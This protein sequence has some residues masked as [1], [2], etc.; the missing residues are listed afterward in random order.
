M[1]VVE[2]CGTHVGVSAPV[3]FE[4][5]GGGHGYD[6]GD[7]NNERRADEHGHGGR[8][9]D[10]RN[11]GEQGDRRKNRIEELRQEQFEEALNLL[12]AFAGGLDHIR[13]LDARPVGRA[14]GHH[15]AVQ[16]GTQSEL[17]P[18]GGFGAEACGVCGGQVAN[19]HAD[20]RQGHVNHEVAGHR[21]DGGARNAEQIGGALGGRGGVT[22]E[23]V[24]VGCG[25]QS[26]QQHDQRKHEADIGKQPNPYQSHFAGYELAETWCQLEQSFVE[27][28]SLPLAV[29][30]RC[31]LPWYCSRSRHASVAGAT[32]RIPAH[33]DGVHCAILFTLGESAHTR[34]TFS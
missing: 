7:N 22:G 33:T 10:R 17:D 27:H 1:Q 5:A 25:E 24:W 31:W 29:L 6:A 19:Q 11:H 34:Q 20:D 15:F 12:D 23:S 32:N 14:E 13:G 3:F 4:G 28:G 2:E 21:G 8:H 18:F 30:L 26:L 9:V 16:L